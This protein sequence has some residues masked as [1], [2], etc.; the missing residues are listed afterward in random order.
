MKKNGFTLAEVLITLG[1]IGVV[2]ALA[3]PALNASV[4]KAKVGPSLRKFVSTM[5]NANDM[6]LGNSEENR[7]SAV[8]KSEK[9]YANYLKPYVKGS[10]VLDKNGNPINYG[11]IGANPKSFDGKKTALASEL[12]YVYTMSDGSEFGMF[13]YATP[14]DVPEGSS[15]YKG[16]LFLIAYDVNGFSKDPNRFGKDIFHFFIDDGGS[17]IPYGGRQ[18]AQEDVWWAALDKLQWEDECAPDKEPVGTQS[19]SF[20]GMACA[21]S[22]ADNNW[23]VVY[24][25]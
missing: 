9:D 2:A 3:A 12:P 6:I 16:R 20:A 5:E 17:V 18:M 15:S 1:I 23:K 11:S 8:I 25:Y 24:K 4:Q 14:G 19:Y 22:V 13:K 21:G 7:L 10:I